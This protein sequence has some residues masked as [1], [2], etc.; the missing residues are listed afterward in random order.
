MS[1]EEKILDLLDKEIKEFSFVNEHFKYD[2]AIGAL[3][4]LK[5][6]KQKIGEIEN[7]ESD[8]RRN[9]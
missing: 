1:K 9:V 2:W 8:L 5:I 3:G 4:A 7:G 6:L